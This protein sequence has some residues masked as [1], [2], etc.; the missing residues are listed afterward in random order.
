MTSYGTMARWN[1]EARNDSGGRDCDC[2]YEVGGCGW[3]IVGSTNP[4]VGHGLKLTRGDRLDTTS[5][6]NT[7]KSR[8]VSLY[9]YTHILYIIDQ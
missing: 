7:L 3:L 4:E 5:T 9:I 8:I 6:Q 2:H 1:H